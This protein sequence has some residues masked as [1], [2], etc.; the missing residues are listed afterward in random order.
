MVTLCQCLSSCL[1]CQSCSPPCCYKTG[2]AEPPGPLRRSQ[3][4][5]AP[6]FCLW[7]L[8]GGTESRPAQR[9]KREVWKW[10]LQTLPLLHPVALGL[11][12]LFLMQF[13][14]TWVLGTQLHLSWPGDTC[15]GSRVPGMLATHGALPVSLLGTVMRLCRLNGLPPCL[16]HGGVIP[17]KAKQSTSGKEISLM[18]VQSNTAGLK[19]CISL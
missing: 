2:G 9:S 4:S 5:F 10:H 14:S 11:P 16:F 19:A 18:I 8:P 17:Q 12:E 6:Q 15:A 3:G 7:V 1:L 13:L